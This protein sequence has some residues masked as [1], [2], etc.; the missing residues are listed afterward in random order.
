MLL[1]G[2]P[3]DARRVPGYWLGA[4]SPEGDELEPLYFSMIEKGRKPTMLEQSGRN[5]HCRWE[6]GP[7]PRL[8]FSSQFEPK[9]NCLSLPMPNDFNGVG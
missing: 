1:F 8:T 2:S 6:S 3:H 9:R 7:K 4:D 5:A